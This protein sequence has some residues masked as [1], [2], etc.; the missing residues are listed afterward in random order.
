[1]IK[2]LK[3]YLLIV[4]A[5][6]CLAC[7]LVGCKI[8]RPGRAELLAGYDSHVTY[9]SNGGDFNGSNTIRVLEIYFKAGDNGVPFFFV[10]NGTG[11]E[12][13]TISRRGYDLRGWYEPAKYT[14]ADAPKPEYAG[15]TKYEITYTADAQG[16]ISDNFVATSPNNV[17]EPVFPV[18][19]N[20]NPVIDED[21]DRPVYARM[22]QSGNLRDEQ[23]NENLIT[24]VCDK[25][26][27]VA[28]F[29]EEDKVVNNFSIERDDAVEVCADWELTA[30][31]SY[32]LIV[33]DETGKILADQE[34]ADPTYYDTVETDDE[35]NEKVTASYKNGDPLVLR[36]MRGDSATPLDMQLV[37][38]KG[39][40]FVKTFMDAELTEPVHSVDRPEGA[41]RIIEVYCRYIVG[42]WTVVSAARTVSRMFTRLGVSSDKFFVLADNENNEI[43]CTGT[44]F[45]L[46]A[47]ASSSATI[48]VDGD[49]PVTISNLNFRINGDVRSNMCYSILGDI[50][51]G[52]KVTGGGLVLKN[53]SITLPRTLINYDFYAVCRSAVSAASANVNITVDTVT[54]TY[55]SSSDVINFGNLSNWLFGSVNLTQFTGLKVVDGGNEDKYYI[56]PAEQQQP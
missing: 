52:F 22:D 47:N 38:I 10:T 26:K 5:A 28:Y 14:E 12:G 18:L 27:P 1:M 20:G 11:K 9:Y 15:T 48:V 34:G 4:F 33:T 42:D 43:D 49:K 19:H 54:A 32:H 50:T 25:D 7:T 35:G 24:V 23:I 41:D 56:R 39:L 6:A 53:I 36:P 29:D 31:I 13:M 17:T 37:E 21:D 51:G 45:D 40:T 55:N 16:N 44:Q 3:V 2:R 46:R 30:S 8:G